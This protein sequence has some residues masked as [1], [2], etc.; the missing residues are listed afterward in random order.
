MAEPLSAVVIT[1]NSER[2]LGACLES[3]A[4]ADELLVIDCGSTDTT[5]AIAARLGARTLHQAWLGYGPQKQFAVTAAR[6]RW[7]L[8]LD[9]DERVSPELRASIAAALD[10]P[11]C[12]AYRMPRQTASWDAGSST[13]RDIPI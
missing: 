5:L 3:A 4:F 2:Q 1:L 7:V 6:N 11:Q 8:T 13:A 9:A 12:V 10:A